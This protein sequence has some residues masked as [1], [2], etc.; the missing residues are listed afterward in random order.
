MYILVFWTIS[1]YG[2][3]KITSS[4]K[5]NEVTEIIIDKM[6]DYFTKILSENYDKKKDKD[7]YSEFLADYVNYWLKIN[8][9]NIEDFFEIKNI[10][11]LKSINQE[12]FIR[13]TSHYYYFFPELI[14]LTEEEFQNVEQLRLKNSNPEIVYHYSKWVSDRCLTFENY[15]VS[16]SVMVLFNNGFTNYLKNG[17]FETFKYLSHLIEHTGN[18]PFFKLASFLTQTEAKSELKYREVREVVTIV[19]WKLLCLQAGINFHTTMPIEN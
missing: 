13:D 15:Y 10:D 2:Q 6:Y 16:H 4:I 1:V 19:F 7:L 14:I 12:L 11:G 3:E 9:N 5:D 8:N 18:V 17:E